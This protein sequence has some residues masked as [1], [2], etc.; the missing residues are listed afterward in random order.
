MLNLKVTDRD[1]TET[2]IEASAGQSVME[3][4][5]DE[6]LP[7]EAVCGGCCS[8]ATCH[9]FVATDWLPRVHPRSSQE[10]DLLDSLE[11]FDQVSSR[12]SCQIKMSAELD[13]L[14]VRLAPE[15]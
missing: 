9:I 7:V 12:L 15:E 5:R 13:G 2:I 4:M 3:V 1:G 14:T 10:T 11:H 8:C 6:G